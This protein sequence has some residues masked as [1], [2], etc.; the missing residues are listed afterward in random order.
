MKTFALILG[1][2]STATCLLADWPSLKGGP[3]RQN[4]G[5]RGLSLPAKVAFSYSA[6]AELY[7][8]PAVVDGLIVLPSSDGYL[9]AISEKNGKLKWRSR[10]PGKVWGSSPA[11]EKGVIA[12]GCDNGCVAFVDLA[13]GKVLNQGCFPKNGFFGKANDITGS[14]LWV[15][16]RVLIGSFNYQLGAF[17]KN[18]QLAWTLD[19]E[20]KL[21]DTAPAY[22]GQRVYVGS[23]DGRIYAVDASNGKLLWRSDSF[24]V[25]NS[26]P[27][28][29]QGKLLVGSGDRKVRSLDPATGQ[30][31][32]AFSTRGKV[33]SSPAWDGA[34]G[35][36]VGDSENSIYHLSLKDGSRLWESRLSGPILAA[37]LVLGQQ[38]W[39]G[40]FE[41][42]LHVLDL[43]TGQSLQSQILPG[44]I[45]AAAV[46]ASGR[47][48]VAGRNGQLTAFEAATAP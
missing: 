37:P 7:A 30:A 47:V 10:M 29:I 8:S 6:G 15:N 20:G 2:L 42:R 14:P 43:A 22:D 12:V 21:R 44:G 28:C 38:V 26:A 35:L 18:G 19:T 45:F 11:V 32:W 24:D 3:L 17:E 16:G 5:P 25:I 13:T 46:P 1:L 4:W 40:D 41:G 23:M 9:H 31:Q 27:A 34:D 36:L 48:L 33:M 39:I